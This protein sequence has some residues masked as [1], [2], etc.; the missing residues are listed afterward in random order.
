MASIKVSELLMY[1]GILEH[2]LGIVHEI[3]MPKALY[4]DNKSN[5]RVVN[6]PSSSEEQKPCNAL[7]DSAKYIKL[8]SY[9]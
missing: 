8:P 4:C 6:N 2:A 1:D 9:G 7:P 5:T 3:D